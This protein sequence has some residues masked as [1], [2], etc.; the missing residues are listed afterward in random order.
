MISDELKCIFIHVH[1]CAGES[2]ELDVFGRAD[3]HFNGDAY[4][5]SP[6][7]HLALKDYFRKYPV[8]TMKYFK[9]ATVRNPWSRLASW[10]RYRDLRY[11]RTEG[12]F[13]DRMMYDL[14]NCKPIRRCTY[15]HMLKMPIGLAK[16]DF[17]LRFE[18]LAEDY[19][20]LLEL[21]GRPIK[22]LSHVNSSFSDTDYR[23]LYTDQLKDEVYRIHRKDVIEFGYEF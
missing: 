10:V 12:S 1:K 15:Q 22:P 11:S 6:N 17:V 14:K 16:V 5:G 3:R 2:I 9:F 19:K 4:E 21:L 13:Q 23:L 8:K 18:N 20:V 7:K